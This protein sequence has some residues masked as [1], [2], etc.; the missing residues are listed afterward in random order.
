MKDESIEQIRKKIDDIDQ[1]IIELVAQ[2]LKIAKELA[3]LKKKLGMEIRDRK[4]E[5]AII[6]RAKKT[7]LELGLDQNFV[8]TLMIYLI[9]NTAAAEKKTMAP[10]P[11]WEKIM[12]AFKEYPAQLN[13]ARILFTHG[14]KVREDGEIACGSM[15]IPAVH[16][17]EAAG[18]DRRV[19]T[20]TAKRI[21][22][23]DELFQIFGNLEPTVFLKN[24]ARGLGLGVIEIIPEDAAKPG[25]IKEVT[26][27]ISKK[28]VNIR[29][30]IADDPYLVLY[31]KL[32]IITDSPVSGDVIEELRKLPSVRSIV[33]Y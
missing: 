24:V 26:D 27:V 21:L 29:Q 19:V 10:P 3:K 18:V 23:N 20:T 1:R 12:N 30:A 9:A 28:N 8:E 31:P 6:N 14:L 2:R 25:I 33:V 11:G 32:T 17:A 7:A 13:V 22:E 15:K 16:V 5:L 4:R